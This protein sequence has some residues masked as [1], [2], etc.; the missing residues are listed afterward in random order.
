MGDTL[1][2]SF[3]G[4]LD[5]LGSSDEEEVTLGVRERAEENIGG[6]L[7]PCEGMPSAKRARK[8]IVSR[9]LN[10]VL[11]LRGSSRFDD[12]LKTISEKLSEDDMGDGTSS[13]TAKACTPVNFEQNDDYRL[14]M[15]SN[16]VVEEIDEE[17]GRIVASVALLYKDKF[18]EL[19]ALVPNKMEY[20]LCVQRIGN[21]MDM[22]KIELSDIL[23]THLLMIVSVTGSTSGGSPLAPDALSEALRGCDEGLSLLHDKERILGFVK[24][25]MGIFAPNIAVIVGVTVAAQLIALAGGVVALSRIPASNMQVLGQQKGK[26]LA[27]FAQTADAGM[28]H[29]GVIYQSDL[30]Q[31]CPRDLRKKIL[32]IVAAKVSLAARVDAY[33]TTTGG[34][35]GHR[36]RSEIEAKIEKLKEGDQMRT[37]KALPVPEDKRKQRRGGKRVRKMKERMATSEMTK[38]RNRLAMGV[39]RDDEDYADSAM[40]RDNGMLGMQGSGKV[41]AVQEKKVS[42][43][44]RKQ[45]KALAASTGNQVNGLSTS[46]IFTPVQGMEL[47]DPNAVKKRIEEANSKWFGTGSGFASA[48]PKD[49]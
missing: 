6:D 43:Q 38:E 33:R 26:L 19:E 32:K 23:P 41:R 47:A 34:E 45:K 46:L 2:D 16:T 48:M 20:L 30:V 4:D 8:G 27:G 35:E 36:L 40:G 14:M 39:G 3:L 10:D 11:T 44:T 9:T 13:S 29:L 42:F 12:V 31:S 49:T 18:P 1:A 7:D 5:D 24:S 22:T 37:H 21:E 15:Q 17:F 28:P 25:R